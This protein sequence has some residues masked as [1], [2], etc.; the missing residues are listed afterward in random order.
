MITKSDHKLY[1]ITNITSRTRRA[2]VLQQQ[3]LFKKQSTIGMHDRSKCKN[4]CI[5]EDDNN[6]NSSDEDKYE[7]EASVPLHS[8]SHSHLQQ[9]QQQQQQQQL[10]ETLNNNQPLK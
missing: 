8:H 10:V 2:A 7:Y 3:L 4:D 9:Q 6:N 5:V 1:L